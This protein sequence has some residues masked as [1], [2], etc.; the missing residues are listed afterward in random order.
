MNKKL[1]LISFPIP[2]GI[3]CFLVMVQILWLCSCQVIREVEN[4]DYAAIVGKPIRV[5]TPGRN[6]YRLEKWSYQDSTI[7]AMEGEVHPAGRGSSLFRTHVEPFNGTLPADSIRHCYYYDVSVPLTIITV[8]GVLAI[9]FW[10][11]VDSMHGF[12]LGGL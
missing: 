6:E 5:V 7:V 10:A 11:A 4:G 1:S 8:A 3:A 9:V 12:R 2:R